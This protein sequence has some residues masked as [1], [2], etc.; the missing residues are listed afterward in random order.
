LN[1]LRCYNNAIPL[2]DLYAA[3]QK[4]SNFNNK[5]LGTQTLPA[6]NAGTNVAV[7]VDNVFN[8]AGTVFTVKKN[9]IAAISGTDYS[10]SGGNI[11]FLT[12]GTYA[13]EIS[14]P[15]ITSNASYPAKV[16]ANYNVT[17]SSS[18][19]KQGDGSITDLEEMANTDISAYVNVNRL[20]V[21]SPKS[22]QITIYS[23]G[24]SLIYQSKKPEGKATFDIGSLP[25]GVLIVRGSSG[26]VRKTVKQ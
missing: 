18:S 16:I 7:V 25:K 17:G 4:I 9:Y 23:L 13:V 22:E 1:L 5:D 11:T 14:N 24:G 26:W 10:L 19:S 12:A 3:S 2:A 15:A 21:N 20:Y 8:G 6:V